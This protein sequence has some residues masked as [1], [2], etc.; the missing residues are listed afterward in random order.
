MLV[1]TLSYLHTHAHIVYVG[2]LTAAAGGEGKGEE[3]E[4][5]LRLVGR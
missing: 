2:R 1:G 3:V 5:H 4:A